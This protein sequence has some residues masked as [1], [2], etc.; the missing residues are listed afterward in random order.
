M[1][2]D[3]AGRGNEKGRTLR[4]GMGMATVRGGGGMAEHEMTAYPLLP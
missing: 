3:C 1:R 2:M 4:T